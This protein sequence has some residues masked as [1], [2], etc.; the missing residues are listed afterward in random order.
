MA[1][2]NVGIGIATPGYKLHVVGDINFTGILNNFI[3]VDGSVD[4]T[5]MFAGSN[6]NYINPEPLKEYKFVKN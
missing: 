3:K 6:T 2:G 1:G 4:D 5:N